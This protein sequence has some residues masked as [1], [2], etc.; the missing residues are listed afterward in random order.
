MQIQRRRRLPLELK[1]EVISALT[2]QHGRRMLLLCNSIAKN[3]IALV[4]KQKGQFENRWDLTACHEG[5]TLSEPD[6]LVVQRNGEGY[7]GWSS[8]RAERPILILIG[9]ATEQMPLNYAV[10]L[11]E[12]TYAYESWGDFWG[13]EVARCPHC[14]GHPY[15]GGKPKFGVGDVVG[16]S[17]NLKKGQIIY[18]L[19]GKRLG[20]NE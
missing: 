19:N 14:N 8:V 13:H 9:L 18:T 16:C 3:C 12:G 5:L 6:R 2:F 7:L 17:I 4:R 11:D 20:E 1:C 15:I 10:G